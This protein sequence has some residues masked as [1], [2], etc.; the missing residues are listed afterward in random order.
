[1]Q[2]KIEDQGGNIQSSVGKTTSFL[3]QEFGKN[4]GSPSEKEVKANKLGVPVISVADLE[5]ML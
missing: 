4:D 1:M 3:I 2:Q 5:K